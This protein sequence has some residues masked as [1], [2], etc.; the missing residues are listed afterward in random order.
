MNNF[1]L[2]VFTFAL[3]AWGIN[4]S[5]PNLSSVDQTGRI[6]LSDSSVFKHPCDGQTLDTALVNS[7]KQEGGS[8][9]TKAKDSK[10]VK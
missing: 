9:E 10:G 5:D 6:V 8:G 7:P 3:P 2:I 4:H 1:L